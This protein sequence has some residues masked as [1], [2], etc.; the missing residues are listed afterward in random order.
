[1]KQIDID[2]F[3]DNLTLK[4]SLH[5][6]DTDHAPL[7]VGSHGLE[8][9]QNS[10]KQMVLSRL[11]PENG[12]AFFRFDHR[13]CGASQGEF[14][15]DTSLEKR[16]R[17]LVAAVGHILSFSHI[18]EELA[19]KKLASDKLDPGKLA[20]FGSSMGGATCINAWQDLS[21]AGMPPMGGILCAAPVISRSIQNIP[22][23]ANGNRPALPLSFF[24]ENLLFNILD[25]AQSLHHVLVF[26]G[27][28][29]EVV[30]VFNAH[31]LYKAMQPPKEIVIHKGGTHQMNA[32]KDQ[33]DFEIRALAWFKDIFDS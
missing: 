24:A 14:S 5:L 7:V 17:D 15:R 10:A 6:P 2:F 20:L 13:G 21:D 33:Q 4:G 16:T 18:S 31:D 22:T 28:A 26:H 9:S 11:L 1:M 25:R 32:K 23:Q 30:P 19:S 3:V 12:M 29:D 8:G 27:D